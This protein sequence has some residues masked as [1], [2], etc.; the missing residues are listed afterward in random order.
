MQSRR[1]SRITTFR[2]DSIGG[3]RRFDSQFVDPASL[4]CKVL[5]I[6]YRFPADSP[7]VAHWIVD[8]DQTPTASL[9]WFCEPE[10]SDLSPINRRSFQDAIGTRMYPRS[11]LDR[12]VLPP[13]CDT[14]RGREKPIPGP[15]NSEKVVKPPMG[16]MRGLRVNEEPKR[17]LRPPLMSR[18]ISGTTSGLGSQLDLPVQP[19]TIFNYAG[20]SDVCVK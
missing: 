13:Y 9:T 12:K 11:C 6:S 4:M 14:G 15:P 3:S 17:H 19:A 5:H 8:P 7:I 10:I 1:K 18:V 20:L 2:A 16:R